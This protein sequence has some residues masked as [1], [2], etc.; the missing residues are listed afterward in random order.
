MK[1][2]LAAFAAAAVAGPS[3]A[4]T[5]T[6]KLPGSGQAQT[7]TVDYSCAGDKVS[8][9]YINAPGNALAVVRIGGATVIMANVLAGSG[10]KYAG[11][12]YVWWTKGREADLYNLTKGEDA[13]GTH[14]VEA[15]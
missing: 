11:G 9:T 13:P 14:C 4:A 10:A 12:Q 5:I 15:G 1:R 7:Q 3:F 6:I 2:I 8:A